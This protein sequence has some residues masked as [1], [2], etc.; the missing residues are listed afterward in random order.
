MIYYFMDVLNLTPMQRFE[1]N[2]SRPIQLFFS[3]FLQTKFFF[4]DQQQCSSVQMKKLII[5][6]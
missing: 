3:V 1:L 2:S 4:T 6:F 5:Y